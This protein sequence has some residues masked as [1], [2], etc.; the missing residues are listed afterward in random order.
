MADLDLWGHLRFGLDFLATGHLDRVDPYSYTAA[1]QPWVNHEWLAEVVAA[2]FYRSLGAAG[3]MLLKVLL[4]A[5]IG[6]AMFMGLRQ[7]GLAPLR[8]WLVVSISLATLMM[9]VVTLR[10]HLFTFLAFALLLLILIR[11]DA[12]GPVGCWRCLCFLQYG[13]TFTGA[14]LQV[15][16]S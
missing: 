2:A 16:L 11:A 5:L 1:G 14:F 15:S 4:A 6:A 10:P 3:L 9:G 12:A 8:S 7:E 13:Q